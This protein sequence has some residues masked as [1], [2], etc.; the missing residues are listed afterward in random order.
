[1]RR[2][3]L[4]RESVSI[5]DEAGQGFIIPPRDKFASADGFTDWAELCQWFDAVYG[6]GRGP[7]EGQ[8]VQWGNAI[9][10]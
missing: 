10:E 6:A 3:I 2:I 9:W 5:F 8:L 4:T 1:V 7:M